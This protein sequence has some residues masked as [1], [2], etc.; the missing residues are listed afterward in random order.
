MDQPEA[1]ADEPAPDHDRAQEEVLGGDEGDRQRDHR[2]HEPVGQHHDVEHGQ[3]QRD[4]VG[5]RERR[6]DLG[7]RQPAAAAQEQPE[8]EEQMIPAG[9]DVLD[10]EENEAGGVPRG[11]ASDAEPG[12]PRGRLE[13]ELARP[14]RPLHLRE[15]VMVATD[16]VEDVVAHVEV[17]QPRRAREIHQ[18]REARGVEGRRLH[19]AGARFAT[20]SVCAQPDRSPDDVEQTL[21]G[22]DA[23]ALGEP[24]ILRHLRRERGGGEGH[25]VSDGAVVDG[26][27][28]VASAPTGVGGDRSG[29]TRRDDQSETR[30]DARALQ[31]PASAR[32]CSHS[33]PMNRDIT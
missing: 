12:F 26:D 7:Q 33:W 19:D 13:S 32:T 28:G 27:R 21:A 18:H 14:A 24:Q 8:Q 2:F 6:D 9:E 10:A 31:R 15:R 17:A 25:A 20:G 5:Q 16:D 29:P 1:E 22:L 3:G 23:T 30:D 11:R 4:A